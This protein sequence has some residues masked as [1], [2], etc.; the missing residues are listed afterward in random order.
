MKVIAGRINSGNITRYWLA[1]DI[2][3]KVGDY[4]IVEINTDYDLIKVVGIIET[5]EELCRYIANVNITKK[6]MK[7]VSIN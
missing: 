6:V 5:T 4:A 1:N 3:C 7:I 2:D